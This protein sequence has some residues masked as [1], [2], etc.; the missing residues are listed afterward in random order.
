[1]ALILTIVAVGVLLL[2]SEWWWRAHRKHGEISRKFIHITVGTF[3]ASWPFFLTWN[4]IIVLSALF[5]FVVSLS[6]HFNVFKAIHAVER[7]TWGEVCFAAS[8]GSLAVLTRSPAIFTAGLL[9]MSLADGLA[10]VMGTT[11]G[12]TNRYKVFGHTKSV[13]GSITFLGVSTC[14]L[15]AYAT[16]AP[17]FISPFYIVAMAAAATVLE[18]MAVLGLDNLLVPLGIG[19]VLTALS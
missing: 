10:A 12:R 15:I 9:H 5:I 1:M 2:V 8:V 19:L 14:I 17:H 6:Q 13:I 11:Y 18:N 7:P 3:A 16:V 4:Q